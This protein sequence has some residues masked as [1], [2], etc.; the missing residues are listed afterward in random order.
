MPMT[1]DALN[2]QTI[3]RANLDVPQGG[4]L[5]VIGIAGIVLAVLPAVLIVLRQVFGL[6]APHVRGVGSRIR[7]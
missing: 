3:R 2:T 6:R 7:D 5:A 4:N 1:T